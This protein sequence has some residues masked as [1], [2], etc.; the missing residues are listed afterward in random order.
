MRTLINLFVLVLLMC[1]ALSAQQNSK[2][3]KGTWNFNP[4]KIWEIDKAGNE[5]F[6]RPGEP[7]I[8]NNGILYLRDFDKK[9]SYIFDAKGTLQNKFAYQ[10]EDKEVSM[11]INCFT[12][13]ESVVIGAMD[14]LHF[15]NSNGDLIKSVDNN[16]FARFPLSF[17]SKSEYLVAPGSLAGIPTG[18]TEIT[19]V[20]PESGSDEKFAEIVLSEE[21]KAL[22]P[23]GVIAGLTPQILTTY[24][25]RNDIIYFCKNSEYKIFV[26]DS[27]GKI[28]DSFGRKEERINV[29]LDARKEHLSFFLDDV[30]DEAITDMAKGLPGKLLYFHNIQVNDGFLYIF[31]MTEFS[32]ELTEQEIDIYSLDGE[33]LYTGTIQ[34]ENGLS[35]KNVNG[36]QIKG[37]NLYALLSNE[38]GRSKIVKYKIDIPVCD[39]GNLPDTHAGKRAAEVIDLLN[40]T[41]KIQAE[42]YIKNQYTPEFRDA[43]PVATHKS[44]YQITNTMFGKVKVV[45]VSKSTENEI[46]AVLESEKGDAWL[47]LIMQVEP[48]KPHRI[49]S[50]GLA[51]GS[52]PAEKKSK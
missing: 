8:G 45:D 11:Y 12:F 15:Y 19:K 6:G 13:G 28:L 48:K 9:F 34:F 26:A 25:D 30:P 42:D 32:T 50:M 18:I 3:E 4:Q 1:N 52:R 14:K 10:G 35:L 23:G 51:P 40:G 22:P 2:P 27:D 24:D 41:S 5:D 37:S 38:N 49:M 17:M 33:F 16:I 7:R 47:N 46:N 43:F 21:E 44:I 39:A 36:L 29:S 31:R 20:N